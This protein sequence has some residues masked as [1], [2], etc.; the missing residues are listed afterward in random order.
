M[1]KRT[2]AM[3]VPKYFLLGWHF[4]CRPLDP[5]LDI[6][7][8]F[9][10]RKKEKFENHKCCISGNIARVPKRFQRLFK[11]MQLFL[12][13]SFFLLHMPGSLP[14]TPVFPILTIH[15]IKLSRCRP[16]VRMKFGHFYYIFLAITG[17]FWSF[18]SLIIWNHFYR[19]ST[20][21]LFH[22]VNSASQN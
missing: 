22:Y 14:Q 1:E 20:W 18:W 9:V 10:K 2:K 3:Y 17:K 13:T 11:K 4:G 6:W 8:N 5:T 16:I 15:Y 12:F 21:V 7:S 19:W